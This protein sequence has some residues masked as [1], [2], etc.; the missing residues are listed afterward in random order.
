MVVGNY[1]ANKGWIYL[2]LVSCLYVLYKA[3]VRTSLPVFM[4]LSLLPL[5]IFAFLLIIN[6][7]K[8]IY[9]MKTSSK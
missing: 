2:L 5:G 4:A 3:T 6:N 7:H 1:F 9:K 8:D